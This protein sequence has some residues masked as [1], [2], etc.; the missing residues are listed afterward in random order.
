M[1]FL[2]GLPAHSTMAGL[3]EK[4]VNLIGRA[5]YADE[6]VVVLQAL[7]R[8]KFLKD[9]EMGNAVNLQ[10]RQVRKIMNELH[11]DMLVCEEVLND[12]RLGGSSSTSYWYIDYKYF[13]EVVQY[14]LYVMQEHLKENE[15]LEIERQTYQ[16]KNSDCGRE[17][18]ALE[19]Q[20]LLMPGQFQF[21]CGHCN[22]VLL[23]CDN[24]DRLEKI[25]A[26]DRKLKD[27]MNRQAGMREGI[28]EVLKRIN[29]YVKE[30]NVLPTNL[31]SEN[32]AAGIGG[33]SVRMGDGAGGANGRGGGGGGGGGGANRVGDGKNAQSYLYPYGTQQ[34]KEIIVDID[35][36]DQGEDEYLV[37]RKRKPE[38]DA[39][40]RPAKAPRALPEFL[41]GSSISGH[42]VKKHL[43]NVNDNVAE[44]T[45]ANVP[46]QSM[47][48][49]GDEE[50]T[51]EQRQEAFKRAYLA[52]LERYNEGNQDSEEVE[53]QVDKQ[54]WDAE[55][56]G[57][58]AEEEELEDVEWEWCD[59]EVDGHIDA[60]VTVMGRTKRLDML[61]DDDLQEMTNE[62]FMEC[63]R[64]CI[65][66]N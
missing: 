26:L 64:L 30:G 16:C 14:R 40:N 21:R 32:R 17:Y 49:L 1:R 35:G 58:N 22:E 54:G 12:K 25:Q 56:N 2:W 4:L 13:V 61:D 45:S 24:N 38:D 6:H 41:K 36:N 27:Q 23:E 5:F 33:K 10:T 63:Y 57:D 48:H 37:D 42:L 53:V 31:P 28:F 59:D 44:D 43:Q 52:E 11:Q 19:V 9:D 15:K 8:E 62:E 39:S 34:E 47:A 66:Q 65:S 60:E 7:I 50:M 51:E 3:V 18:T 55:M 46:L 29:D 20:R